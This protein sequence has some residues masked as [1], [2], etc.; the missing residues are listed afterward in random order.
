MAVRFENVT[1]ERDGISILDGVTASV[2]KGSCTAIIG[3]NG[4]GKTTLLLAL[5]GEITYQ[6]RI[7]PCRLKRR[8]RIGYV[9]QRLALIGACR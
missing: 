3:P 8:P 9:P 7:Y 4:S 6:G 2:P 5:L 1:V